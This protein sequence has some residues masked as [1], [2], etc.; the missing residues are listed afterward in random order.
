MP[1][2]SPRPE[3][4]VRSVHRL[5][6]LAYLFCVGVFVFRYRSEAPT[7]G[8]YTKRYLI[9][10]ILPFLVIA[11][12]TVLVSS[13]RS[14]PRSGRSERLRARLPAPLAWMA[15]AGML[16]ALSGAPVMPV[17]IQGSGRALPRGAV[18]PRPVRVTVAFGTP[19]RFARERGRGRYQEISDGIMAAIG[20]LKSEAERGGR[21]AAHD[22]RTDPTTPGAALAGR[23]H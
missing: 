1:T 23:I 8:P 22:P 2:D 17:Y 7:I 20:R 6:C 13:T 15:G 9:G 11:A 12:V 18:V 19:I 21:A 4:F 10:V 14:R 5:A 3:A 16:A